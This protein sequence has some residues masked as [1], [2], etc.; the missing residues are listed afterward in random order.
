VIYTAE[1]WSQI[2]TSIGYSFCDDELAKVCS[3][4]MYVFFVYKT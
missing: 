1:L 3:I 4:V 2:I